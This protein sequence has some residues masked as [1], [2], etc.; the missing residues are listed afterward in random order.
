MWSWQRS[1]PVPRHGRLRS[2]HRTCLQNPDDFEIFPKAEGG[3]I[4]VTFGGEA[5]KDGSTAQLTVIAKT[6]DSAAYV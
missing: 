4:P 5:L 6:A 2:R 1:T 3:K